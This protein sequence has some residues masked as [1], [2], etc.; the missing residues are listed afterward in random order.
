MIITPFLSSI[1]HDLKISVQFIV[2]Y[3]HSTIDGYGSNGGDA[4]E[5]PKPPTAEETESVLLDYYREFLDVCYVVLPSDK[6][7]LNQA[8]EIPVLPDS[9]IIVEA[10][11]E[12]TIFDNS[13]KNPGSVMC[14]I[15]NGRA[16]SGQIDLGDMISITLE[17]FEEAQSIL[18]IVFDINSSVEVGASV[19]ESGLKSDETGNWA[20][21][22]Y[23][24]KKEVM[25]KDDFP[26]VEFV[27]KFTYC[28]KI[29][30]GGDPTIFD[31]IF[32]FVEEHREELE[33][34]GV[35]LIVIIAAVI[36]WE[37]GAGTAGTVATG[38]FIEKIL[39]KL[40]Q[41]I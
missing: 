40:A 31:P 4:I 19:L 23:S 24:I 17:G 18:D 21:V 15:S 37:V 35:A 27:F 9:K 10:S 29:H 7:K 6:I 22:A 8:V 20:Y 36:A 13:A 5:V 2:A 26:P 32:A 1:L 33:I 38:A 16:F 30:N 11:S 3:P 41:I 34:V 25:V 14:D 28:V 12:T 39:S